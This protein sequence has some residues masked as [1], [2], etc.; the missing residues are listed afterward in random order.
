MNP[1]SIIPA[2][3]NFPKEAELVGAILSGYSVL[4]FWLAHC[5]RS[6]LGDDPDTAIK[7]LFRIRGEEQRILIADA[8]M[9]HKFAS[10]A[11]HGL[12][13]E[14][15]ADLHFCRKIR[16]QYAHCYWELPFG[17]T[18]KYLIFVDLEVVAKRAGETRIDTQ[19]T[20][21]LKTLQLQANYFLFV[22][23][24]LAHLYDEHEKLAGRPPTHTVPLPKKMTRPPQSNGKP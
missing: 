6:A 1:T 8:L 2:F 23:Q 13:C 17:N 3:K 24:C 18:P 21:D 20:V 22:R 11:L 9:R 7:V 19:E 4:E 14:A 16:N 5:L 10:S 15:I 12:Y